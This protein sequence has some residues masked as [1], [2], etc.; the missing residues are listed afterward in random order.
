MLFF[1]ARKGRINATLISSEGRVYKRF[2]LGGGARFGD[3][4]KQ[5]RVYS[6]EVLLKLLKM[7]E[8]E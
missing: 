1:A 8:A 4:V 7:F 2:A 6:T 3:V 5:D